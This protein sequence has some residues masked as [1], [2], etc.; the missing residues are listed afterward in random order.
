ME[1]KG[2][3]FDQNYCIGC[4]TCMSACR[5]R[6]GIKPG[7]YPRKASSSQIQIIGPFLSVA[8]NHCDNPACVA[9][10]PTG[11]LQKRESDGVVTHDSEVCIGCYSCVSACPY[12]AP[13]QNEITGKMV[14]CDMC[15][16][17]L[18][19]GDTPACVLSCPLKVLSVGTVAEFEAGGAVREGLDFTVYDTAPNLRFIKR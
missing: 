15:V 9:I 11:A 13:Q 14:K 12:D 8:C 7:V 2:F 16:A 4:Q 17:R 19:S 3:L 10:C 1:Q 18:D 6:H 5:V